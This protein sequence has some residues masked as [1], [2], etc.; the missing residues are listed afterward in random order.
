M[1]TPWTKET[2]PQPRKYAIRCE[3]EL[4]DGSQCYV[5]MYRH[6]H[7]KNPR[8]HDCSKR[9]R[10]EKPR[11]DANNYKLHA[12]Q[13]RVLRIILAECGY[14]WDVVEDF[15]AQ[16]RRTPLG[17]FPKPESRAYAFDVRMHRRYKEKNRDR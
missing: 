2:R 4:Q 1:N 15:R 13:A 16:L 8:C 3:G 9:E 12:E 11:T 5:V 17:D 7:K 10:K 14:S 6:A